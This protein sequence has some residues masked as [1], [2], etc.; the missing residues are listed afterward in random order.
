MADPLPLLDCFAALDDPRSGNATRHVLSDILTIAICAITAGAEAW[1]EV[2]RFGQ[3]K[4]TWFEGF[5]ALPGGI[6][7]HDTFGRVFA[8]LDPEA[9]QRV[10]RQWT[11]SVNAHTEGEVIA[12]DGKTARCSANAAT[13]QPALHL[14]SAWAAANRL[15]LAQVPTEAHS[16]EITALPELLRLLYVRGCIVTIDAAGCQRALAQQI[17]GQGGDYVLALKGNHPTLHQD[18]VSYFTE[19][20]ASRLASLAF[21]EQTD[22]GHGRVE[23]RRCW[24]SGD[25]AWLERAAE[26]TGLRT[27]AMVEA[28]RHL[29]ETITRMRRYYLS[30]LEADA[31]RLLEVVR[32]HW[33]VE[34]KLHWVLDVVYHEDQ[35]PVRSGHAAENLSTLRRWTM[36]L[37]RQDATRD[38][39]KGKRQRAGW[40]NDYLVRLLNIQMR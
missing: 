34:N 36:N 6:P 35:S 1:T 8:A 18:V 39:L 23:V 29:G 2:E 30:S 11:A 5:L 13:A 26:W 27:I 10:F 20:P 21:A 38:S 37:L 4:R 14:V 24:A 33:E 3:A 19:A 17:R 16:N 40:D 15:V 25:V 22:G 9:F 7:S 12:L 31:A 28:E 32:T